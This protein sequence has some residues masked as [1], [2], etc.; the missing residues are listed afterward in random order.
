[1]MRTRWLLILAPAVLAAAVAAPWRK[2]P[3]PPQLLFGPLYSAV[4]LAHVFPDSKEFA[5]AVPKEAPARIRAAYGKQHP[6]TPA[7]LKRFVFD[8]FTLP[9]AAPEKHIR[10]GLPLGRHIDALWPV[11]TRQPRPVPPN[12]SL[13]PLPYPYV[14]PGGRFR[15]MYYWDS[16][17]TMLGLAQSGRMDL[18]KDMVRDFAALIDRYGH[19]PNG[20]RTYYLTRSQPPFFYAMVALTDPHHPAA[21]WARWLPELKR[22]YAYWMGREHVV[23]MP[24]GELLNRYWGG[25]DLP[26]DESYAEDVALAARTHRPARVVYRN[27]RAAA[28]SG[29]DFSSRWFAD[30]KSLAAIDTVDVVPVDLN[31]LLY[32]LEKAIGLGCERIKDRACTDGFASRAARRRQAMDK[33]LWNA[34]RGAFLDWR[35]DTRAQVPR[36]TA[37][38][39]Y[40]L[41]TGAASKKQA[42]AVAEA[43]RALVKPGGLVT[44]LTD[45]GQQWDAPNGW[46][47]LQ[48]IAVDGLNRNGAPKLAGAIACRWLVNVRAVYRKTGK[49][50]EKYDV[51]HLGRPG[52]GGEYPLQD[53]FGWTNG[54]T[55]KLMA[56][57]PAYV[58][59]YSPTQCP[60]VR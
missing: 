52:G 51:E 56:L 43:A 15:E 24:D 38:T 55:K 58:M 13:L 47:P 50:M 29:W 57:Y 53:G 30:G 46:A 45:T 8:H 10:A 18:V 34:Q 6:Q 22:E 33:Y 1:M 2:P 26:R 5:D 37:A 7:A 28:E 12:S 40:P 35:T 31:A 54:V 48:W 60:K 11:L 21:A 4:E 19:V 9:H 14:V 17:F 39:L 27:L 20:N 23:R 32:G 42:Q 44:T 41:F 36:I 49:L 16:Y 3:P 59:Y 25:R